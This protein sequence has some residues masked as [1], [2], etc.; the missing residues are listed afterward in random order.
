MV[1]R[2]QVSCSFYVLARL[3]NNLFSK[4]QP[5]FVSI[6][7]VLPQETRGSVEITDQN[8]DAVHERRSMV[9]VVYSWAFFPSPLLITFNSHQIASHE[10]LCIQCMIY[11]Q[12]AHAIRH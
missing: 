9:Y 5:N 4:T 6:P 12:L 2:V 10:T 7:P 3:Q 11:S 8:I 1:P